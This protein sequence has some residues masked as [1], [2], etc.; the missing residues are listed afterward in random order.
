MLMP[1]YA[2]GIDCAK[3]I[4]IIKMTKKS[5]IFFSTMSDLGSWNGLLRCWG[6]KHYELLF[7]LSVKVETAWQRAKK[8]ITQRV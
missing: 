3:I 8:E 1:Y 6:K 7:L 5:L 2:L 4:I